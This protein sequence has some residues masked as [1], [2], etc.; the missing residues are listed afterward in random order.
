[1]EIT[2]IIPRVGTIC[3][4]PELN[5]R[6]GFEKDSQDISWEILSTATYQDND[7]NIRTICTMLALNS[8]DAEDMGIEPEKIDLALYD[9][10]HV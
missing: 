10:K 6:N 8:A 3:H 1:M 5:R 9:H 7:G 4:V 2:V